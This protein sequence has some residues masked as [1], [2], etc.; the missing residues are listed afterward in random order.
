MVIGF[1]TSERYNPPR[2]SGGQTKEREGTGGRTTNTNQKQKT[3]KN[4]GY[5][6]IEQQNTAPSKLLEGCE[7][8]KNA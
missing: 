8:L 3:R 5:Y 7:S 4:T 6:G 1:Q 2:N